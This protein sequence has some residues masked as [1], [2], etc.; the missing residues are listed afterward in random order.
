MKKLGCIWL[1]LFIVV[2]FFYCENADAQEY[3]F[4]KNY[5]RITE[6]SIDISANN[7]KMRFTAV[8]ESDGTWKTEEDHGRMIFVKKG[9]ILK[10]QGERLILIYN[11]VIQRITW[12]IDDKYLYEKIQTYEQY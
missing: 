3:T 2:S 7:W 4:A 9:A 1:A 11:D 6:D 8:R 12:T 10:K 5:T